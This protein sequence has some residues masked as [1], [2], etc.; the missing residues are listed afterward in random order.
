MRK[1][2]KQFVTNQNL[3]TVK[4]NVA[5]SDNSNSEHKEEKETEAVTSSK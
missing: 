4:I 2:S 5:E 1:F 3:S